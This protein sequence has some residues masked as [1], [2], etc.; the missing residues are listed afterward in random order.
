MPDG[1]F[2]SGPAESLPFPDGRFDI[3]T[4]LGSLEHFLEPV[5]ALREMVRVATRDAVFIILVPNSG[6]LTRRLGL[7]RG[8]YQTAAK[9]EVRSL[10]EWDRLFQSAG[11]QLTDRWKDLHVLSWS[12]IVSLGWSRV[13]IRALQ[14]MA[15]LFWP[16]DWQY[17]V[18][19]ALRI[20][21]GYPVRP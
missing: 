3:V 7:Y 18:Y 21:T 19:H 12:W 4:C 20:R 16:L 10:R 17:Q 1:E 5:E 2:H 6:F 15:L 14:G 8:T 13:P 11:L 9:E